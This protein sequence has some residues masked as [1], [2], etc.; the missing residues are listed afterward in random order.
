MESL[1]S[2]PRDV[3]LRHI[4]SASPRI[5]KCARSKIEIILYTRKEIL[6]VFHKK[7]PPFRSRSLA[8]RRRYWYFLTGEQMAFLSQRETIYHRSQWLKEIATFVT[9]ERTKDCQWT[10]ICC[11]FSQIHHIS[12]VSYQ[13]YCMYVS[14]I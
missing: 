6:L 10:F 8:G 9:G 12:L 7:A 3:Y 4:I 2:A 13:M 14:H 11:N 5:R 1:A